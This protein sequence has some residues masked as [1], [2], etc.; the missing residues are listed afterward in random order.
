MKTIAID[1]DGV[2]HK[3]S[4]GWS[5]GSIYDEPF[6]GVFKAIS[7]LM[8][9]HSVF[10]LSTR[11]PWQIKRWLDK[12]LWTYAPMEVPAGVDDKLYFYGYRAG[13]IPF[14]TKFWNKP[15]LL[16]ITNKKLPAEIYI[17]DRALKFEG[18]WP[19]TL[20]LIKL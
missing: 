18:S 2:I 3:Y 15:Y 17:D 10:I 16:G 7:E 6:D 12:H 4:K 14:W 8:K 1:F 19:D 5:D 20:E 9:T 13:V 11:S